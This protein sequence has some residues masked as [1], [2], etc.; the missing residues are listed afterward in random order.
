[1]YDLR[2]TIEKVFERLEKEHNAKWAETGLC[3]KNQLINALSQREKSIHEYLGYKSS[4][5]VSKAI[6][7][8]IPEISLLKNKNIKWIN[9]FLDIDD[10]FFCSSCKTV[11]DKNVRIS[12]KTRITNLCKSCDTKKTQV[13][14]N[15]NRTKLY[16][17]LLESSC[18]DCNIKNPVVLEFDHRDP[19]S[20]LFNISNMMNNSWKD[21]QKEIDKCDI[22]CAN[23]HRIRTA[24]T[25]N[26]Y[27]S[28]T[29]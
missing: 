26:W 23:C 17:V 13:Y 22:V 15:I 20:K 11:L 25:Q 2:E 9:F 10:K 18:M 1:M 12:S 14:Y 29:G 4:A 21:I 5:G 3:T 24:K 28:L 27:A 7:T 8:A 16:N 19:K 6:H